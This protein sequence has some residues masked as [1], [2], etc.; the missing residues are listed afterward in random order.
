[1]TR[2]SAFVF[3]L[4]VSALAASLC[5]G[6][7]AAASSN[8]A[9]M[10]EVPALSPEQVA[11][12]EYN[13][14]LELRDK[15]MEADRKA[16]AETN[17]KKKAKLEKKRDEL[18]RK[19]SRRFDVAVENKSDFAQAHGSLGYALRR[20]GRFE[21][22]MGAYDKAL[23]INPNYSPAMEYRAEALLGLGRV[24]EAQ[25]AYEKLTMISAEHAAQLL[26]ALGAW[27]ND[28]AN[29]AAAAEAGLDDWIAGRESTAAATSSGAEG[30]PSSWR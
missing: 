18:F 5:A 11:V 2:Y 17:A 6:P 22:A 25:E 15:A 28:N 10:P 12:N 16:Q 24:A 29:S 14:G 26:T 19:A 4:A 7:L 27:A 3:T 8:D 13:A 20:L 21:E 9:P 30:G 1:M 23:Q